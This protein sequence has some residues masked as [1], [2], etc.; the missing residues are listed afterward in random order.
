MATSLVARRVLGIGHR[1]ARAIAK[2]NTLDSFRKAI[3]AGLHMIEFDINYSKDRVLLVY[4]DDHTP[5]GQD[6]GDITFEKFMEYDGDHVSLET[7]LTC[8]D[9]V[10]SGVSLYFDIKSAR[11]VEPLGA[12]LTSLVQEGT[13]RASQIWIAAFNKQI[14][15]DFLAQRRSNELLR[16]I[17]VGGLFDEDDRL[18][19]NPVPLYTELGVDFLSVRHNFITKELVDDCHSSNILVLTWVTNT[20][21]LCEHML[22]CGVDGLCGDVPDVLMKYQ[23]V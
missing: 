15:L 6:L 8:T 16:D 13:Y 14:V 2:D 5:D 12:Y 4:H 23:Q 10:Q 11:A 7:M 19:E 9:I 21:T 18:P 22:S 1:G 3:S 17:K 20:E